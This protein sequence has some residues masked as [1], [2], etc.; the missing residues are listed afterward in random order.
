[1]GKDC[2]GM[3]RITMALTEHPGDHNSKKSME[4][5]LASPGLGDL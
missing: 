5:A 2:L 4:A 3:G 1:M